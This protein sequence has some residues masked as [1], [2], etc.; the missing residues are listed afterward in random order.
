MSDGNYAV[1]KCA[2]S[3][4]TSTSTKNPSARPDGNLPANNLDITPGIENMEERAFH[5]QEGVDQ[6]QVLDAAK[7]IIYKG[8]DD[9]SQSMS[10]IED[11]KSRPHI[12]T[13]SQLEKVQQMS[14]E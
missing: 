1:S 13:T 10:S 14:T 3:M 5:I 12:R 6:R 7:G 11:D 4:M 2:S 8:P 9:S